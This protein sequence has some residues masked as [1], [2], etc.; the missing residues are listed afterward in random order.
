MEQWAKGVIQSGLAPETL[1]TAP[2]VIVATQYGLEIGLS[3]MVA[4]N[5]ICVVK[6]KP[7]LWGDAALA[8][9]KRS[10]LA[11][12][13]RET[14]EVDG[15]NIIA[16]VESKRT[17]TGEIVK[18]EFSSLDAKTARLWDKKGSWQTHPKRMLKYKARAFNLRDN[19]PDVLQGLHLTEEMEGEND[20]LPAPDC[21]TPARGDRR[22]K[23]D[24]TLTREDAEIARMA[25]QAQ[26]KAYSPPP[27]K[28]AEASTDV[29]SEVNASVGGEVIEAE[30]VD[31]GDPE[32]EAETAKMK[33]INDLDELKDS[34]DEKEGDNFTEY[35]SEILCRGEDEVEDENDWT[36][37]MVEQVKR[38]L[39]AEGI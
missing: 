29:D 27:D 12:Y 24:S 13:V 4:L 22:K 3:P 28:P 33:V 34:Y 17:D 35:A 39:A 10:G 8:L 11:A 37:Q 25:G 23:V 9:V 20:P 14:I 18:S 7:T 31:E 21:D 38:H 19:F 16:R 15:Q 6:G 36:A 5:S 1:N 26:A 2:K 30:V 32:L